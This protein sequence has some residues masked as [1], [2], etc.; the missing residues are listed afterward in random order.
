MVSFIVERKGLPELF[1]NWV[2]F[3]LTFSILDFS[4][5]EPLCLLVDMDYEIGPIWL[6]VLVVKQELCELLLISLQMLFPNCLAKCIFE[7]FRITE[8]PKNNKNEKYHDHNDSV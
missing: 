2:L 4:F 3:F 7:Q 8:L 6:I 1:D 5:N